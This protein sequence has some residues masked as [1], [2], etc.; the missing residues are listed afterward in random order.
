MERTCVCAY[1]DADGMA[2]LPEPTFVWRLP[3]PD[4][5]LRSLTRNGENAGCTW[6]G[7]SPHAV[8]L[9]STNKETPLWAPDERPIYYWTSA[10][11]DQENALGVNYQAGITPIPK[12]RTSGSVGYR[13]VREAEP[14]DGGT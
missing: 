5:V 13:C 11:Q 2:L 14:P 12:S 9:E 1:L 8:C 4:E 3:T 10:E 6:D 7:R